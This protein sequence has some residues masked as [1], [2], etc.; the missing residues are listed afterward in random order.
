M[1]LFSV[2]KDFPKPPL[3]PQAHSDYITKQ[4]AHSQGFVYDRL[5]QMSTSYQSSEGNKSTLRHLLPTP[6]ILDK[7][8][9]HTPTETSPHLALHHGWK[10]THQPA[11][12]GPALPYPTRGSGSF[13]SH[14]GMQHS[15]SDATRSQPP[16]CAA[17]PVLPT[18]W[19]LK[20]RPARGSVFVTLACFAG[21]VIQFWEGG[22]LC[23]VSFFFFPCL[24]I[25]VPSVVQLKLE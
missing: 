3:V 8:Q 21:A 19:V 20:W 2:L 14:A 18:R 25:H 6:H 24:K 23:F 7:K 15:T 16:S 9:Q 5:R 4:A 12:P 10:A 11:K 17:A 1:K 13:C 22:M